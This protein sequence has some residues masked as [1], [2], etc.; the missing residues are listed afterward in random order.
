[1]SN[2][3]IHKKHQENIVQTTKFKDLKVILLVLWN[4]GMRKD[5][6]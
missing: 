2:E 3:C 4:F 5:I 6:L 1:M